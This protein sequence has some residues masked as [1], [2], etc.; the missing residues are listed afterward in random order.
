MSSAIVTREQAS[1]IIVAVTK[2]RLQKNSTPHLVMMILKSFGVNT[3]IHV[4]ELANVSSAINLD[5]IV[6]ILKRPLDK[7]YLFRDGDYYAL[8]PVGNQVLYN[9]AELHPSPDA[10][11][12]K[13]G[14]E[15]IY[16]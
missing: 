4:Q 11:S 9:L 1:S 7:G 13:E 2:P 6:T 3:F 10:L 16:A 15:D 14:D 5:R 8:T 12:E